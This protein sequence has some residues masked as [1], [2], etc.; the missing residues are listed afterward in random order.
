MTE[1]A[2]GSPRERRT[3]LQNPFATQVFQLGPTTPDK[4]SGPHDIAGP[5]WKRPCDEERIRPRVE[6]PF[7]WIKTVAG[8]RKLRY[9]GR[10]RKRAWFLIAGAVHNLLRITLDAQLA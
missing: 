2:Q 10:R 8:G 6:E 1:H 5:T 4:S 3:C 7:G 9:K